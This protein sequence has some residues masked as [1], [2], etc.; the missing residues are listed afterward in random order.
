MLREARPKRETCNH[1]PTVTLNIA[2]ELSI[3]TIP[4]AT[5]AP[6]ISAVT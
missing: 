4:T 5:T 2:Q 3:L 1:S 6:L